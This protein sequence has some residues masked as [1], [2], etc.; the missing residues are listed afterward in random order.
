[1]SKE[2]SRREFLRGAGVL[3][4]A[5]GGTVLFG[6][7]H[8]RGA[9]SMDSCLALEGKSEEEVKEN[10][11]IVSLSKDTLG[12]RLLT[13]NQEDEVTS[14]N[15]EEKK[16]PY[17]VWRLPLPSVEGCEEVRKYKTY[18]VFSEGELG[19][20]SCSARAEIFYADWA[21]EGEGAWRVF[22]TGGNPSPG[23]WCSALIADCDSQDST[24]AVLEKLVE[25]GSSRGAWCT[26][27]HDCV[28]SGGKV[29]IPSIQACKEIEDIY[30]E[31]K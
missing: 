12:A 4:A 19:P 5:V 24:R 20:H 29:N 9:N 21:K 17:F 13:E 11:G 30:C 1:M 7:Y 2:I 28:R 15:L 26:N 10:I 6:G 18:K 14:G 27:I 3:V 23:E 22:V 31:L 8:E 16:G 25:G